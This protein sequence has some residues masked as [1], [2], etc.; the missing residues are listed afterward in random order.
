MKPKSIML[1]IPLQQ[2]EIE[3]Q[4]RTEGTE[5]TERGCDTY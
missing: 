3:V 1:L 5:T 2:K 4:Q